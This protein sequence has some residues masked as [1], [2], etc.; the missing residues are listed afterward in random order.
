M[1][2]FDRVLHPVRCSD[3]GMEDH[4]VVGLGGN[5]LPNVVDLDRQLAMAPV[6][7]C[8]DTDMGGATK[9]HERIH[10]R[11]DRPA[12]ADH[13]LDQDHHAVIDGGRHLGAA[14]EGA[15]PSG[16][17]VIAVER[18]VQNPEG[19]P[20]TGQAFEIV[21]ENSAEGNTAVRD[22]H[23][24]EPIDSIGALDDLVCH[25]HEGAA[26]RLIVEDDPL[27]RGGVGPGD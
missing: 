19:Y 2:L 13:I 25:A 26:N 5:I 24:I 6:D 9:I 23:Q 1:T 14:Q 10:A 17:E 16:R 11:A 27:G 20:L 3:L 22:R 12:R 4:L 15:T 18:R 21:R 8:D 7:E